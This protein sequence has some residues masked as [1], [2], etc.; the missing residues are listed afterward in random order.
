[1]AGLDLRP[2]DWFCDTSTPVDDATATVDRFFRC[3]GDV[4]AWLSSSRLRLNPAKTQVLWLGYKYQLLKLDVH[5]VQILTTSDRIVDSARDLG[6]VIDSAL[7]MSEHVTA[8][9]AVGGDLSGLAAQFSDESA[10]EVCI[11]VMRYT[12]RSLYFYFY[13][14][15]CRSAYYQLRQLYA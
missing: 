15:V 2:R 9:Q 3:I 8:V 12:N 10:L 13:F 14:A 5:D 11:H 6:I 1:M 4:E 7:T